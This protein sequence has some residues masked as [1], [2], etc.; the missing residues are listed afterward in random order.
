[1]AA[2]QV[3]AVRTAAR[4]VTSLDRPLS[5]DDEGASSLSHFIAGTDPGPEELLTLS[6]T[7]QKLRDAISTLPEEERQIIELR[8]G[9]DSEPQPLTIKEIARRMRIPARKVQALEAS[10]LERLALNREIQALREAA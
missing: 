5:S 4:A 6:L 7:Q 8:F 10:G 3:T 2:S 1:M 9:V